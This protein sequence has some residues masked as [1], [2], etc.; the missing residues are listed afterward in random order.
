MKKGLALLL[1]LV[2]VLAAVPAFAAGKL[3]V[4]QENFHVIDSYGLYG[5]AYAKVENTGDKPVEF[6]AGL[7][8]IYNADGDT[9][10]STDYIHA[11]AEYLQP[12]EYTYVSAYDDIDTTDNAADVSDYML[13]ITGK[14]SNDA[15]THRFPCE[16][17]Y[18][19]DVQVRTYSTS[20]CMY[21][22]FTNDT[23]Q[24][25]YS[26]EVVLA[27]LD[28]E[29]NIL[30]MEDTSFYSDVAV[31]PGSSICVRKEVSDSFKEYMEKNNLVPASVDAIA[32]YYIEE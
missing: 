16:T 12:G 30:Y 13:T 4:T 21:A 11:Y 15:S 3:T 17:S 9:L 6:S 32:Y 2:I 18:E 20:D 7:L 28:A 10:T 23:D 29:G 25:V 27:L 1:A 8:E 24:P 19:K 31:M 22:T 5:Y 14:S 26:I